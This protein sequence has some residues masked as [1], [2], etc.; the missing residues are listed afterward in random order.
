MTPQELLSKS[1]LALKDQGCR[2]AVHTSNG[3]ECSY[4][5]DTGLRCGIGHLLTEDQAVTWQYKLGGDVAYILRNNRG[6]PAIPGWV[7]PNIELLSELQNAHDGLGDW[8]DPVSGFE[9]AFKKLAKQFQLAL[10]K[11]ET[12][13]QSNLG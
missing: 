10:P 9:R 4:I 5:T 2:G 11:G 3:T 8:D 13:A 1:Y 12:N 7:E 6:D